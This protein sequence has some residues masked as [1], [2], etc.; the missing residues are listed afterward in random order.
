MFDK[1]TGELIAV[2]VLINGVSYQMDKVDLWK[3][4]NIASTYF[5][6]L[7]LPEHTET[8]HQKVLE[9]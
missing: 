5:D 2:D 9:M 3:L 6:V 1:D 8:N 4:Y 7:P